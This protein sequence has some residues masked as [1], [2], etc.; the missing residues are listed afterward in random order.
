MSDSIASLLER[1]FDADYA[2]AAAYNESAAVIHK[3]NARVQDLQAELN[4]LRKSFMALRDDRDVWQAR[5]ETSI[6]A[7]R[8]FIDQGALNR[9]EI[10]SVRDEIWPR[11]LEEVKARNS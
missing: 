9:D 2:A 5:E 1:G 3:L 11:K 6:E 4:S 8:Q 7:V 10:N